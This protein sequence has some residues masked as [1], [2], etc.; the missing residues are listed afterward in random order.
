MTKITQLLAIVLIIAFT[1]KNYAQIGI[2]TTSPNSSAMLDIESSEA[3]ILIPRMTETERDAIAVDATTIGLLIYQ[4]NNAPGFYYYNGSAWVPFGGA[5]DSDWTVVGND[6]YNANSGNVGIGTT[7]PSSKFHIEDIA[8]VTDLL[9]DGFEDNSLAP[10]TSTDWFITS[11]GQEV[12]TGTY[13]ASSGAI[14]DS[15]TSFIEYTVT[16]PAGGASLSFAYRVS[17]ESNYD[18]LRFYIDGIQQNQWSGDVAYTTISYAL[19]AG[20][21]TLRW[22]YEKDSSTSSLRDE[23]YIDDIVITPSTSGSA[24]RIVDGGQATGKVLTSDANGNASW[25]IPT[26]GAAD[27]DWIISGNDMYNANSGNVGVGTIS[28][29]HGLHVEHNEDNAGVMKIQNDTSGG[30]A[31]IYFFQSTNYKGHVGYVNTG[32]TSGF[33]E[34]GTFQVASG[35]RDFV[36]STNDTDENFSETLRITQDKKLRISDNSGVVSP[37]YWE[38][39]VDVADDYNFAFNGTLEAYILDGSGAFQITSDR[40]LKKNISPIKDS[41][42]EKVLALNPVNYIYKKDKNKLLQNGF[43]AQ[44]VQELFPELVDEKNGYL[45]LNYDGF[46]V[47]AVKAIQEQQKKIKS[48]EERINHLEEEINLIKKMLLSQKK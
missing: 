31:G 25:Q 15:Q 6:M 11:T 47:L 4:T 1:N 37:D 26:A 35:N 45:S 24:I 7:T 48:Q 30:F 23:V 38:T 33:A 42:I 3:G 14:G 5:A 27:N 13:A 28:P 36:I 22:S 43:I 39:Y 32:G 18:F 41:T 12:N 46:S 8:V 34:K 17:S 21:Q 29:T 9:N 20:T 40:R 16:V 19:A 44:E 10:F 2:G